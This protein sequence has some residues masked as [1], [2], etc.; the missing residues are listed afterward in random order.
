[1]LHFLIIL[2]QNP[3]FSVRLCSF[4]VFLLRCLHFG[5]ILCTLAANPSNARF[6]STLFKPAALTHHTLRNFGSSLFYCG[7]AEEQEA[8][9][10][11]E[12]HMLLFSKPRFDPLGHRAGLC[13]GLILALCGSIPHT[14]GH[15]TSY[16][17]SFS[18]WC[19]DS[20]SHIN[21]S[22][23]EIAVWLRQRL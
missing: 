3:A 6:H 19:R 4:Y 14:R 13:C 2:I 20:L 23:T 15:D 11:A 5:W 18:R 1:M 16:W 21:R 17:S 7:A 8:S 10:E 9:A 22:N 12:V